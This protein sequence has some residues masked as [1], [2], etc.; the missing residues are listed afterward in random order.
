[1]IQ[2]T[3]IYLVRHGE[4][5]FNAGT[6]IKGDPELTEKGIL[7]AR[8]IAKKLRSIH[9]DA[10]FSSDFIRAKRTA[11][12][13]AVE[14]KLAVKTTKLIRERDFG[15]TFEK[16]RKQA[17]EAIKAAIQNLS[18]KEKLN[19]KH[20][21]DIEPEYDAVSRLITF[22]REIA[23]S[24]QGKT[25]LVVAHGNLMRSLLVHLGWASYDELP[26]GS[27]ANTG[28]IHL[29]SDDTDFFV[30]DT[31]KVTKNII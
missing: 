8:D 27:L 30:R 14:R 3:T 10:I 16:N 2:K 22:L 18:D 19:Y 17:V 15:P 24:H 11:E 29:E 7:Q 31:Y 21:E 28:Y 9:F 26:S 25:V 23:V 12:I 20:F 4:S 6:H 13:M 1:M 5:T